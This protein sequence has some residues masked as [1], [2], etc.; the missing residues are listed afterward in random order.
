M[1]TA[2]SGNELEQGASGTAVAEPHVAPPGSP[3]GAP[4]LPVATSPGA[5]RWREVWRES[6]RALALPIAALAFLLA[7]GAAWFGGSRGWADGIW[8][9]GLVI[10]GTLPVWRTVREA[11]R[12]QLATDI[13]ATLAI[14]TAAAIGQPF[15][16]LV[17]VLMLTGGEA[18]D[19]YAA[20]RASA[21]VRELEAAAPRVAHRSHPDGTIQDVAAEAVRVGDVLLVRPGELVPCDSVVVS[22]RSHVDAS[23]LTGEPVP[24]TAE[25]GTQLL[26]GSANQEGPLTV[27]ATAVAR[28]SQYLRIVDLV[29][30]AQASKAPLQRLADRYAVWFT[31]ATLLVCLAAWLV[32]RDM[33]R[34]LA[35]L[36]VA[37]PCPLI[38]ATPIAM[39]GGI[40]RAAA[41]QI[42]VR[43]GG[44][45]EQLAAVTVAVFDKTGTLTLGRP[46]VQRVEV[47]DGWE[48]RDVLRLAGAV[49]LGSGHLLA[50][51]LVDAA[52]RAL[53][54]EPLPAA[55][56]VVEVPGR[57][58]SGRVGG[59]LVTVGARALVASGV[60]ASGDLA[61]LD[62]RFA[63]AVGLRA[64]VAVDDRVVG[65][66]DYAD[67]VRPAAHTLVEELRGLGIHRTV[68]LSG[69][70]SA[71]VRAVAEAVGVTSARGDLLP[72]QKVDEVRALMSAGEQVV[73]VGD[74][75]ND[76]PA[77][78]TANVGVA[79]A[80][81][82]GQG[83]GITAEAADVVILADDLGR[84]ADAVRISRRTMRVARQS[85]AVG[86][87]LSVAA[88]VV[89]AL[90]YI[91]PAVGALL[92][93]GIDIAVI[94][95]ALRASR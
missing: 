10:T 8:M 80:G 4:P 5:R 6:G 60:P 76:A 50:R 66:V 26:S 87:G 94:V 85:L 92:Q 41:R 28:E 48:E 73:M 53:R 14:V 38:L 77:L 93:E 58:V 74:G 71:N 35:V 68:L 82:A 1:A 51:S 15:A 29:R 11:L 33:D 31:P 55:T 54:G 75:T 91:P 62:S 24:V 2:E 36:V 46:E 86:L 19:R 18:L 42:I 52:L 95:N 3:S 25:A 89:A 69:D 34:V 83:G 7:G 27:R 40:N 21:A 56:E 72:Q 16:G 45:L 88:M 17:I 43:N 65:V 61:A 57:G 47:A 30:S 32:S 90:G 23:R 20:G 12:G 64:Y 78:S 13:V 67:Q 79:L 63:D 37:T 44:A 59:R 70:H 81:S 39:I 84:V 22:G 49:E 9:V